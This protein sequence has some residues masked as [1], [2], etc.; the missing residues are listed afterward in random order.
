MRTLIIGTGN[1]LRADDGIGWAVAAQLAEHPETPEARAIACGQ[2]IPEWA[3][4]LEHVDLIIFVESAYGSPAGVVT[5]TALYPEP[6]PKRPAGHGAAPD[7]LDKVTPGQLLGLARRAYGDVPLAF[8]LTVT[9]EFF[10]H[11]EG[12]SPPVQRACP[13]VVRC[14]N[15]LILQYGGVTLKSCGVPVT[16]MYGYA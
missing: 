9:G 4:V 2:L 3:A 11:S 6:T 8:V 13:K 7:K 5:C 14:I 12:L 16:E 15:D 10:G 1:P